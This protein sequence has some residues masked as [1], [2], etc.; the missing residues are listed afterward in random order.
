M[1]WYNASWR[2]RR[3]IAVNNAAGAAS[4][5]DVTLTIPVEDDLFWNNVLST[6]YDVRFAGAD[7]STLVAYKRTSWT[8][9]SRAAVFELSALVVET[10]ACAA[11]LYWHNPQATDGATTP[12]IASAKTGTVFL[13]QPR[14][15]AVAVQPE[16]PGATAP[17]QVFAKASA[18]ERWV[19]WDFR[20]QL[21]PAASPIAGSKA[22]EEIRTV[23]A[24]QVLDDAEAAQAGMVDT[25]KTRLLEG[26]VGTWLK[27]GT[28]GEDY[29]AL[30]RVKTTLD[31]V[32]EARCRVRVRD[33]EV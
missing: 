12:T 28:S 19:W 29:V 1:S 17:R 11:W 32:L 4:P 13:G 14:G 25:S 15:F 24:V 2:R 27:G 21:H 23:S 5:Q 7:G 6:G 16:R 30:C 20:D 8:Y 3:P 33:V 22:W 9:A 26:R 10:G 18:D 31:R